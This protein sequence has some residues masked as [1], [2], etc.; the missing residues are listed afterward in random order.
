MGIQVAQA[1]EGLEKQHGRGPN[2]RTSAKP[3]QD[4][5]ADQGLNLKQQKS[6][7]KNRQRKWQKTPRI[8]RLSWYGMVHDEGLML[9]ATL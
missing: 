1:Q 2:G 6:A 8:G 9:F 5:F 3:W 4:L 7:C